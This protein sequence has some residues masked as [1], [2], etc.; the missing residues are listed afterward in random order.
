MSTELH[1]FWPELR[2]K[3]IGMQDGLA[4]VNGLRLHLKVASF[5][6]DSLRGNAV[7]LKRIQRGFIGNTARFSE[8]EKIDDPSGIWLNR[9]KKSPPWGRD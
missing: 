3:T 4:L 1:A 7:R 2:L 6:S 5:L 8:H 9:R